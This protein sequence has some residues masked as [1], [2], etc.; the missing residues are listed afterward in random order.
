MKS[1]ASSHFL[2]LLLIVALT[3]MAH[4]A[5][6]YGALIRG[7]ETSWLTAGR[8]LTLLSILAILPI[9]LARFA[10]FQGNWTLY[11]SANAGTAYVQGWE[12]S[13]QQQFTFLPGLLKGLSGSLNYTIID[14]HGN[15]GTGSARVIA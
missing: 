1:R 13:Y 11:T 10:K 4:Y 8:N 12:F 7:Y 2:I 15:F 14:T 5:I 3:A 6:Y 9:F